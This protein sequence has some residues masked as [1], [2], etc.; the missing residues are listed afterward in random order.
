MI[1]ITK[2][3]SKCKIEKDIS[4]FEKRPDSIDGHRHYCRQCKK[5][6]TDKYIK[7]YK[8]DGSDSFWRIRAKSFNSGKGRRNGIAGIIID[9]SI[10]ISPEELK[11]LYNNSSNCI[12]CGINLKCDEVV[13]DHKIPLSRNGQHHIDNICVCCK[14]CNNLKGNKTDLEFVDFLKE[15]IYRFKI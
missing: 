5:Q 10:P 13:F 3:C 8:Q 9:S 11:Q 15:Y 7:Q 2:I 6:Q 14:D 4:E 1:K 12:Y